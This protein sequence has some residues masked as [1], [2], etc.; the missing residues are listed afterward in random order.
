MIE[1]D[2]G[3]F[4]LVVLP[5][6][7]LLAAFGIPIWILGWFLGDFIQAVA[8]VIV[9]FFILAIAVTLI[10]VSENVARRPERIDQ[11]IGDK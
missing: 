2:I 5:A 6:A 10:A 9:G 7:A 11:R 3:F 8:V 1:K 4:R